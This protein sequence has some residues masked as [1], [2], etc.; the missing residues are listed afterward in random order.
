[1]GDAAYYLSTSTLVRA[2]AR[3]TIVL[4]SDGYANKLTGNGAGYAR[5]MADYAANQDV[6]VYTISLGNDADESLMQDI[7]TRTGGLHFDATGSGATTL[8]Q[9]LTTAFREI[10]AEI[11]RVQLVE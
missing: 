5:S 11:K 7:A 6:T 3:K 9:R 10:A 2:D 8:T 1:L 4:L